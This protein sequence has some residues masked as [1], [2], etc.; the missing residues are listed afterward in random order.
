MPQLAGLTLPEEMRLV[1]WQ[2]T[3]SEPELLHFL[4]PYPGLLTEAADIKA[5][6]TRLQHLAAR[7]ALSVLLPVGKKAIGVAK[8]VT[9][10]PFLLPNPQQGSISLS[11]T[12]GLAA[13][14]WAPHAVAVDIE[15]LRR[16]RSPSLASMFMHAE[17]L[18]IYHRLGAI[19]RDLA[20]RY[21]YKLWC[22]KE[23]LFKLYARPDEA[24]SFRNQLRI[25][26]DYDHLEAPEG[27]MDGEAQFTDTQHSLT[28]HFFHLEGYLLVVGND[29]HLEQS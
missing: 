9:G 3:E 24:L 13:A 2:I 12:A 18:K 1:C 25:H 29:K 16:K 26:L 15:D 7:A 8:S 22:G 10:R 19:N 28:L 14:I 20:D 6:S 11:H 5:P 17:E 4:S 23:C 27:Q 21:F